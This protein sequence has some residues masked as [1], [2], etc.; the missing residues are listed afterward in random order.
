MSKAYS[1]VTYQSVTDPVRFAAYTELAGPAI[2]AAGGRFIARGLPIASPEGRRG[3]RVVVIEYDSVG[4]A[5]AAYASEGYQK[6]LQVLGNAAIRD[7]RI[8]SGISQHA[9]SV[10][11]H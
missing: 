7:Y 10:S 4:A 6:A 8:V 9:S 3:Q 2:E 11:F 1:V 5:K